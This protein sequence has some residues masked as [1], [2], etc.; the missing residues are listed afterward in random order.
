MF[1]RLLSGSTE[2]PGGA[3]PHAATAPEFAE[4]AD[5]QE[6]LNVLVRAIR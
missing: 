6:F 3:L 5:L 2:R 4:A 1:I